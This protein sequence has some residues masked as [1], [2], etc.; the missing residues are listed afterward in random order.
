MIS[1]FFIYLLLQNCKMKGL[2]IANILS[3]NCHLIQIELVEQVLLF[4][5]QIWLYQLLSHLYWLHL[6]QLLIFCMFVKQN[7]FLPS[8]P[9]LPFKILEKHYIFRDLK[10]QKSNKIFWRSWYKFI[11]S[12]WFNITNVNNWFLISSLITNGKYSMWFSSKEEKALINTFTFP[13]CD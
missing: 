3:L 13:Y 11:Y 8:L 1:L 7:Y 12:S 6:F 2:S 9:N 5:E 10:L 4:I